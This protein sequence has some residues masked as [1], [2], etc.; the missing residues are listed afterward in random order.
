MG[1]VTGT[2]EGGTELDVQQRFLALHAVYQGDPLEI[3]TEWHRVFD[4]DDMAVSADYDNTA[5]YVQVSALLSGRWQPYARW[6]STDY[7]FSDP[8]M[9]AIGPDEYDVL[10]GGLGYRLGGTNVLRAEIRHFDRDGNEN[11]ELVTQWAVGFW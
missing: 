5:Y 2:P 3:I 7:D 6:E 1:R 4:E 8:Y 9:A 10:L 11:T